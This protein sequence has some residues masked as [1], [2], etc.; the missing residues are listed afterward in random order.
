MVW[1]N[2]IKQPVAPHLRGEWELRSV[3]GL[4][5]RAPKI[6]EL[7]RTLPTGSEHSGRGIVLASPYLCHFTALHHNRR[8]RRRDAT[9]RASSSQRSSPP[10]PPSRL[11]A[12]RASDAGNPSSGHCA[13]RKSILQSYSRAILTSN[14][15]ASPSRRQ[16]QMPSSV[17]DGLSEVHV[18]PR[19][20]QGRSV[21]QHSVT[22]GV[23]TETAQ[24]GTRCRQ[25]RAGSGEGH[26]SCGSRGSCR[27]CRERKLEP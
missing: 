4:V 21:A 20:H 2:N 10:P 7:Y 17:L 16:R 24:G 9:P 3:L 8:K 26:R 14:L 23:A 18:R 25:A 1:N 15:V 11:A 5:V 13:L 22:D 27:R 6:G 19:T 12:V